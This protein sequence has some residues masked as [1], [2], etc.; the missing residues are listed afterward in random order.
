MTNY[1]DA[2]EGNILTRIQTKAIL[3][4]DLSIG[5]KTLHEI[6]EVVNHA[7]AFA[8]VKNVLRKE[9]C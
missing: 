1:Q 3:E 2:A 6:Y 9:N 7:K 4:D 5:G 8:F